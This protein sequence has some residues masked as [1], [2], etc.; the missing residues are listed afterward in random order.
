MICTF[1]TVFPWRAVVAAGAAAAALAVAH[2]G[3]AHSLPVTPIDGRWTATITRTGLMRTGEVDPAS[4]AKLYG[5]YTVRFANGRFQIRNERTG[6]GAAGTFTVSGELVRF[7]FA[8][9]VGLK[10][11]DVG[12]CTE[13]VYR[14]R[15]TFTKVPGRPCRAFNAAVWTRVR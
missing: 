4:A 10:R 15:L 8:Y 12:V 11:G 2:A 5:P 6:R 9:G 3:N 7:V 1:H 13:S 14:D